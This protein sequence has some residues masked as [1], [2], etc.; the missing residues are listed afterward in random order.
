MY[1]NHNLS[2][3]YKILEKKLD[4]QKENLLI[5]L[6][7]IRISC[8]GIL[9]INMYYFYCYFFLLK[10]VS[11]HFKLVLLFVHSSGF[12]LSSLFL[13]FYK[14]IKIYNNISILRFIY[15]LFIIILLLAGS[16]PLIINYKF[17]NSIDSYAIMMLISAVWFPFEHIFMITAF[18]INHII[19]MLGINMHFSNSLIS[20]L[21]KQ[22]NANTILLASILLCYSLHKNR[23]KEFSNKCHLIESEHNFKKLFN[24]NPQP[25]FISQ[26]KDDK[27]I[28]SNNKAS[29][30]LGYSNDEFNKISL[31][32][33]YKNEKDKY[34]M[35][36]NILSKSKIK[37]CIVEYKCK[38]GNIKWVITNHELIEY[39]GEECILTSITDITNLKKIEDELLNRASMDSLTG[40]LNR[41]SGIKILEYNL[42]LC[43]NIGASLSLCFIDINDLKLV[44]DTYG[45]SEG[46]ILIRTVCEVIQKNISSSD[47]IYRYGGDEFI[48]LF[49]FKDETY[50]ENIWN[51]I[52]NDF[53]KYNF[54]QLKPY[55]V[56][57]SHGVFEF[58]NSI[59][60]TTEE[61]LHLADKKMYLEKLMK[62]S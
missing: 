62:K 7:R 4:F 21:S 51:S 2:L 18:I 9:S 55:S 49:P 35:L 14:K 16:L 46:D 54:S 41:Y 13:I 10:D 39:Y 17:V 53:Q 5:A 29:I 1:N 60:Y 42:S 31:G 33:L 19:L 28:T 38:S 26:Y 22:I 45:H 23:L 8:I 40:V 27:I 12:I 34:N 24:A 15:R 11:K 59:D 25:L 47:I 56:S 61:I 57:A 20:I 48:I 36:E 50:A 52:K 37:E 58:N 6:D 32:D 43:K 44:N 30:F 3:S